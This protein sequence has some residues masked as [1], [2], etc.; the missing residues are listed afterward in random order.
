MRVYDPTGTVP[1]AARARASWSPV[2]QAGTV[3]GAQRAARTLCDAAPRGGVE[4]GL[5]FWLAQAEI[6]LS[7]LL[8][9]A[10]H[11][12]QHMGTVCSWVLTQD[13]PSERGPGDV[14]TSLKYLASRDDV[15][16][17]LAAAEIADSLEAIWEMEERT[18]SSVYATAQTVVWPWSAP[19][20]AMSSTGEDF[21]SIPIPVRM[22]SGAPGTRS[23]TADFKV[24]VGRELRRRGASRSRPATV[25][26]G[27]SVDEIERA[28]PG[29]DPRLPDQRLVYPLL[30]LG[31][32]RADC[33]RVI[34]DAG[35]PVPGRSACWF[36]PF[37]S[38]EE[39]RRLKRQHP[40]LFTRACWLERHL[41]D[42]RRRLGRDD[43]WLTRHRRPLS[44]V[45]D[46]QLVLDG[47]DG[48][49]SGWCAS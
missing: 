5:D 45:V 15:D 9:V 18:R 34:A 38:A 1:G 6:L 22:S 26:L 24:R 41:N 19:S 16:V 14:R 36:C 12:R 49:D 47:F 37:H 43:V 3:V 48:C 4:G 25:A 40:D 10:H 21:R 28:R 31:L 29:I 17:A 39:W 35:L 33:Q 46:D 30:D 2:R 42:R 44:E 32:T 27:I 8:F 23:C 7:G 20:V 13:R 11:T